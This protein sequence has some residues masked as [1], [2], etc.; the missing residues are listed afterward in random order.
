MSTTKVITAV[1][2]KLIKTKKMFSAFDVTLKIRDMGVYCMHSALKKDI[3]SVMDDVMNDGSTNYIKTLV[4]TG[5]YRTFVYHL[6][7]DSPH[8][9]NSPVDPATGEER[10]VNSVDTGNLS[11]EKAEEKISKA[12]MKPDQTKWW[13]LDMNVTNT[14]AVSRDGRGRIC[15]PAD[16]LRSIGATVGTAVII[17][18]D[19]DKVVIK[20]YDPCQFIPKDNYVYK[21]DRDNNVRISACILAKANMG[22]LWTN[23]FEI[24]QN[25]GEIEIMVLT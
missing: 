22:S 3:H 17:L 21:V 23:K 15:I 1:I 9:Y 4:D 8:G 14:R 6:D 12:M 7:T 19:T 10:L 2:D 11:E 20:C 24:V 13:L 25:D 18:P 16:M 5:T